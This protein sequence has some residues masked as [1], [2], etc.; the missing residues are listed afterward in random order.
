M[1]KRTEEQPYQWEEDLDATQVLP[2]SSTASPTTE[3][4]RL[5]PSLPD[6]DPTRVLPTASSRTAPSA[7]SYRGSEDPTVAFSPL[8]QSASAPQAGAT[9]PLPTSTRQ[10]AALV[11]QAAQ[12]Q[13]TPSRGLQ[14]L[15]PSNIRQTRP[16]AWAIFQHFMSLVTLLFM[17]W[18]T[19]AFFIQTSTGQ[20]LDETAYDEFSY[21]FLNYQEQTLKMLDMIPAASGVVALIGLIFVLIWKHRFVPAI[22]GIL[23]ALGA[24][25]STQILKNYLIIKPDYGIQ[26]AILNS[27]PSGHTTF[28]AAAGAALFLASPKK[29]RPSIALL[30]ALFT[31]AA[32]FSTV[33]NGWHRPSDVM[34]A[35]F[36]TGAWTVI[37]LMILRFMRSEELDM[38]NTQRSGLIL[39]PL[40]TIT[41][42]FM[43]FCA[44]VLYL[45]NAYE[46]FSGA[47]LA[48]ASALIISAATFTMSTLISLLRPQNK[49][50]KAYTKV[51][52]Y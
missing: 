19:I 27:A 34:S 48:A 11:A 3:A 46:P 25:A 47:T 36:L 24:N 45:I 51:W 32:G 21:Q 50:R 12:A 22:V 30:G 17:L 20:A 6:E 42:F 31:T 10:P 39:V 26:E 44:G 38:S 40:S 14:T 41:C 7:P 15:R 9:Q 4:T 35:I 8:K 2:Q 23:I 5:I 16:T 29:L 13:P 18:A 28:A 33:V 1:T 43:L 37:G 52:T 49:Q